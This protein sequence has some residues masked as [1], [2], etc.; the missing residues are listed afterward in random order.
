[1]WNVNL[2]N[3]SF[4]LHFTHSTEPG[5]SNFAMAQDLLLNPLHQ[6]SGATF[7]SWQDWI[8]PWRFTG[9][10][11]EYQ[12]VRQN[13]GLIDWSTMDLIGV[14]GADRIPFLHNLL[15]ND[16]KALK[17]GS[18]CHAGLV[19]PT[20]K[21][22]ADLIVL[23]DAE[24]HWLLVDGSR[25]ETVLKTLDRYHITEEVTLHG[26]T[27]QQAVFALQGPNSLSV[28]QRILNV[29]LRF[30]RPLDHVMVKSESTPVRLVAHSPTGEPGVV[31][32]VLAEQA[33]WLWDL[34]SQR[35]RPHGLVCVGWEALNTL[36]IEAGI[37]WYGVDMDEESLLPETGLEAHAV[38]DT[39]G[40]YVG[41]EV[42]AR[43]QTYGSVSRKLMGL[44][45]EGQVVPQANDPI[46]SARGGSAFGGKDGERLGTIT[47]ACFS[48]TL[49]KPIAMGYVKRPFYEVGTRVTV[50][51]G[52]QALP[53]TLVKRPFI[54]Q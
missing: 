22:L 24:A 19:S 40:C 31:L 2:P 23:A 3:K 45:C 53:A 13:C 6:Q 37:P 15:T 11:A 7:Q 26:Q 20:A 16:I 1:M 51:R 50:M 42:I 41:Q 25:T 32:I 54:K 34:L 44:V 17:P 43:L 35:G 46:T 12:A 52:E 28:L 21:L 9:L 5:Y 39:K 47:S 36:R 18:G 27:T 14:R 29:Q 33:A 48:P 4:T 10:D 8:V 49:G 38:S 30:Q